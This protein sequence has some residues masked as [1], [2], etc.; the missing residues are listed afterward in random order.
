MSITEFIAEHGTPIVDPDRKEIPLPLELTLHRD[1]KALFMR[2]E[3]GTFDHPILKSVDMTFPVPTTFIFNTHDGR[4]YH[5]SILNALTAAVG[6][7]I[8][9][10]K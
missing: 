6:A 5:V 7:A 10:D 8:E 3:L 1:N 4:N 9:A 2:Q